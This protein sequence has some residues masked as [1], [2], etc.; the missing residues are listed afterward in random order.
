MKKMIFGIVELGVF[1]LCLSFII[2]A[3]NL[4]DSN[5]KYLVVLGLLVI[6]IFVKMKI[7]GILRNKMSNG[8]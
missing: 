6:W 1:A 2:K 7:I 5:F 8:K 3:L 4:S